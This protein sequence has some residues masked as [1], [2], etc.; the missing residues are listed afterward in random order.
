MCKYI[1]ILNENLTQ[2]QQQMCKGLITCRKASMNVKP[3]GIPGNSIVR[4]PS[5]S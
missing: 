4:E 3:L 2:A 5:V 1:M